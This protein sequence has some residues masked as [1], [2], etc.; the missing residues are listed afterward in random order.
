MAE[1]EA[2]S[3]WQVVSQS[4][5]LEDRK[6][7][8]FVQHNGSRGTARENI[9]RKVLAE[10][11]IEPYRISTGFVVVPH[12]IQITSD[13]CDVLV[14]DPRLGQPLYR[15]EEF[16]VVPGDAFRLAIEVRSSMSV[17]KGLEQVVKVH[18][19]LRTSFPGALFGFG[20]RGP[21][22]KT[23]LKGIAAKL[24]C[25]ARNLPECIAVHD[26]NYI[27][28]RV[29]DSQN[30]AVDKAVVLAID[31]GHSAPNEGL[32]TAFFLWCCA[33]R[34]NHLAAFSSDMVALKARDWGI[35][36]KDLWQIQLDGT[37]KQGFDRK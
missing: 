16:V 10:H 13:Q 3:Y 30:E 9:L 14:Y 20:F 11:I 31:F 2:L 7:Q 34:V 26:R 33:E 17:K 22:I 21:S 25:E 8:L 37:V 12:A 15:I 29:K 24:N 36:H 23:L 35:P 28:I 19:S 32:A 4:I 27:C 1:K 6:L 5:M 18:N